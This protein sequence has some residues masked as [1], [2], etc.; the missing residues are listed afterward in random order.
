MN[1]YVVLQKNQGQDTR[2]PPPRTVIRD[3]T[4][5]H[6]RFGC[7]HLRP[8]GQFT[9]TRRSDG[10]PDPDGTLKEGTIV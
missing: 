3:F 5:T 2:L 9:D 4:M 7:S 10:A 1:D 6:V 8:T